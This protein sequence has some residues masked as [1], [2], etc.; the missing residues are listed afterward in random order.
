MQLANNHPQPS[1]SE[2]KKVYAAEHQPGSPAALLPEL[3]DTGHVPRG[4][5][6]PDVVKVTHENAAIGSAGQGQR[7]QE[8]V[9]FCL[10]VTA[11]AG[12]ATTAAI[13]CNIKFKSIK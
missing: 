6:P 7:G 11:G 4:E 1:E 10:S 3:H 9:A 5:D 8:L 12:N 2:V 13:S